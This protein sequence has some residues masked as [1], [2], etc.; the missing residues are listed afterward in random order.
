MIVSLSL[1]WIIFAD[2]NIAVRFPVQGKLDLLVSR[3]FFVWFKDYLEFLF[4]VCVWA[5]LLSCFS[6]YYVSVLSG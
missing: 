3:H 4:C 6:S 2:Y 1:A 5:C